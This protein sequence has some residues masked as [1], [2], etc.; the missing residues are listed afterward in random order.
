MLQE[1]A[2]DKMASQL[3]GPA[4]SVAGVVSSGEC[5]LGDFVVMTCACQINNS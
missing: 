1:V 5:A 2:R 4:S 3:A